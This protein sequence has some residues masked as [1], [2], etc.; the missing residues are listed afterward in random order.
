MFRKII[1]GEA[2]F[3]GFWKRAGFINLKTTPFIT[4]SPFANT[5]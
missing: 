5:T 1:R 2:G 4:I 3:K